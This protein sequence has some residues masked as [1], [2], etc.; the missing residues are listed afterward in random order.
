MEEYCKDNIM[1]TNY[2]FIMIIITTFIFT[3]TEEIAVDMEKVHTLRSELPQ[4]IIQ[5]NPDGSETMI[6][7]CGFVDI[8]NEGQ[9]II[10]QRIQ[11]WT[12][13]NPQSR[14]L[15]I[16]VAFH[17][18]YASNNQGYV[19]ESA[20][21]EQIN[22]LNA[23]YVQ[24]GISFTLS[25]LDYTQNSSW[26][27]NDSEN[28]YKQ[29]LAISP[30]TTLNI[31][32]TTAG[33]YL[34]YAYFPNSFPESS[35]M[36]GVVLNYLS[37]PNVY[38]WQ[39]DEGDTGVHEVGHYLGLYHTFE[40]G[41]FGNGDHVSDTPAQDDENNIFNCWTMDTCP[42]SSGND[43]IHNYMNYTDDA[44]LTEFT[45]GQSDRIDYMLATYK[46]NLGNQTGCTDS[47]ACNYDPD[48]ANNDGSCEYPEEHYDCNGNCMVE[49][50]CAGNC[51]IIG[52]EGCYW[53][54]TGP[55]GEAGPSNGIDSC[56]VCGGDNSSC[57]DCAGVPCSNAYED[58]CGVC[59]DDPTND[60]VQGCDGIWGSGAEVDE[61]GICNGDNAC[62][63]CETPFIDI[64]GHCLHGD[65]IAVLQ[66]FIDNSLNSGFVIEG[67]DDSDDPWCSSPN[68][69]MDQS[70]NWH[71]VIIDGV[72]Y[73]F[74]NDNGVVEPLE[75]G[76][77]DWVDGRLLSLMCGSY[78]YCQL[79]GQIPQNI[80]ELSEIEILRLE[81]NY[82]S[83]EIPESVC[84]L[85]NIN[86]SDY[87]AFNFSYNMLC[88]PY[89]E[90]VEE[91]AVEYM[92]T[93]ECWTNGDVNYDGAIDVLDVVIMV[94]AIL[95]NIDIADGDINGDGDI[96][97]IDIVAL[98][99]IILYGE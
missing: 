94:D 68:L 80:S 43:P 44:C 67:C 16:P 66:A 65:D 23:S 93:S 20:V 39:Y 81:V 15:S 84:E 38:N 28:Q 2:L 6:G 52:E 91:G 14:D 83:G 59:D 19:S 10:E 98:V 73:Q 48:A 58:N 53:Q 40:G 72:S 75:L 95:N 69:Y 35:Y 46:P 26:F 77:Q 99:N 49:P 50:D 87:L 64:D 97:V 4:N 32:T 74:S 78:I 1:K 51:C 47:S 89:P 60:C 54:D 12:S 55:C 82:F 34:G 45:A 9:E 29:A 79:S 85:G 76:L 18:I 63:S 31:Y 92:D 71:D 96:N 27:N 90:C 88:P 56:G 62:L 7:R 11:D 17:V 22:V 42:S 70:E 41:C 61:C 36:H 33:G 25:S 57:A 37:L 3:Q 86:F 8:E 24:W 30:S 13:S 21:D 5:T